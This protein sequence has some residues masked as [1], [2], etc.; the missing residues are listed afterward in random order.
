MNA[1]PSADLEN[2]RNVHTVIIGGGQAGLAMSRCLMDNDLTRENHVILERGEIGERWRSSYWDSLHMLTPKWQSRL[3]GGFSYQGNDPEQFMSAN[4]F[5]DYLE[6]YADSFQAP[7]ETNVTV[8]SVQS[9]EGERHD[10]KQGS[11]FLVT[12]DNGSSWRAK[13]VVIATGYSW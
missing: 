2:A 3:P 10:D 7:I 4:E 6:A 5:V 11:R 12:T 8:T 1:S 13:N 9:L